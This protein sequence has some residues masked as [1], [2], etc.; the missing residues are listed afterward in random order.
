MVTTQ[1][2][3]TMLIG[4]VA[5]AIVGLVTKASTSGQ[6]KAVLLALISAAVGIGQGFVD[7]PPDQVWNWQVAVFYAITSFITAVA[8]YFGLYKPENSSGVSPVKVLQGKFIKDQPPL[9]ET[10]TDQAA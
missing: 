1:M 5:P 8:T 7:T 9:D 3:V 2:I 10:Y 4:V 6:V